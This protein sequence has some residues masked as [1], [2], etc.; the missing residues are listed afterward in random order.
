MDTNLPCATRTSAASAQRQLSARLPHK[1]GRGVPPLA[2]SH[3][4]SG[5]VKTQTKTTE[6][7][8]PMRRSPT[9]TTIFEKRDGAH[10]LAPGLRRNSGSSVNSPRAGG[11]TLGSRRSRPGGS[12]AGRSGAPH[13]A[14]C[15]LSALPSPAPRGPCSLRVR[16]TPPPGTK[17]CG[18]P[19]CPWVRRHWRSALPARPLQ[20]PSLPGR[21]Q[22]PC[23]PRRALGRADSRAQRRRGRAEGQAPFLRA[24]GPPW[25][26]S[27]DGRRARQSRD[28]A[29]GC[30]TARSQSRREKAARPTVSFPRVKPALRATRR[31][32]G[33]PAAALA[34][35][36]FPGGGAKRWWRARRGCGAAQED[37]F[38]GRALFGPGRGRGAGD[39]GSRGVAG[40]RRRS[41]RWRGRHR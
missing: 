39:G 27:P 5:D 12:E 21:T 18:A 28:G 4:R 37:V 25:P 8:A 19:R 26:A 3:Q 11:D 20:D 9:L 14:D 30:L 29:R 15:C 13:A 22:Y 24:A 7:A 17:G 36:T 35:R 16:L 1:P 40:R 6:H 33:R 34:L 38:P 2:G 10:T 41:A 31:G 32:G 23:A